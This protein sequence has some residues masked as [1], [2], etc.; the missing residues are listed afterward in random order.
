MAQ[1]QRF[2]FIFSTASGHTNPSF[3]IAR[4]LVK[5]GHSVT[6]LSSSNFRAAI[7]ATG[8]VF[9]DEATVLTEF[10]QA[11][12]NYSAASQALMAEFGCESMPFHLQNLKLG[13]VRIERQLPGLLRF[14]NEGAYDA[15]VY[16][17][18]M[19]PSATHACSLL[20][21]PAAG[22]FTVAGPGAIE[23]FLSDA[24]SKAGIGL[25][26]LDRAYFEDEVNTAAMLRL[27]ERYPGIALP[28]ERP[29]SLPVNNCYLGGPKAAT[30]VTTIEPLCDAVSER[31]ASALD[32][33]KVTFF[34]IGPSL[35]VEGAARAGGFVF[36][37]KEEQVAP[38][39][40]HRHRSDVQDTGDSALA[41]VKQAKKLGVPVV[42]V[43]L[44]TV[45]TSDL[46]TVGW[47]SREAD[48]EG[49]AFG[50][51]S[52]QLVQSVFRAAFDE[53]GAPEVAVAGRGSF[54]EACSNGAP[55]IV[56][57]TGPQPDALDGLAVPPN[58]VCRSYIAQVD[59]LSSGAVSMFVTHGGQNSFTESMAKGV[60]LVVVPGFGDQPVNGRKAESLGL[61]LAVPRPKE[62]GDA[63]LS[64]YVRDLRQAMR[65]VL[66]GD[67]YRAKAREMAEAIRG[68]GG[69]G[70]AAEIVI[71]L[72]EAGR[73]RPH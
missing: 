35:D 3:P 11:A 25:E 16:D 62:D 17:P 26:D 28:K 32:E 66:E 72:A 12:D 39:T 7:E 22:L 20:S 27:R 47:E 50:I 53:F 57:S 31:T 36:S 71:G 48:G 51:T 38:P 64:E 34:H 10:F 67:S 56:C 70:R 5:R 69:A 49:K 58:A 15:V 23:A 40:L 68:A 54:T 46:P 21:I 61:G 18:L 65:G 24:V 13:N 33:A 9:V 59:L 14:L 41:A 42:Y 45:L 55:L 19:L 1:Q 30:L 63:V 2:I 6:Y 60:P 8:A 29:F 44:G 73:G 37:K 43:S 4:H 52:K